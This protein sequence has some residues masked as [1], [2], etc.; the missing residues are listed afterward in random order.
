L[1][2]LTCISTPS[3]ILIVEDDPEF[4]L[5]VQYN[6]KAAGY[7]IVMM[8]NGSAAAAWLGLH[9]ADLMIVDCKVPGLSGIELVR[10]MRP[11][12]GFPPAILMTGDAGRYDRNFLLSLGAVD[13]LLKP[14]SMSELIACVERGLAPE[15]YSRLEYLAAQ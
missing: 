7:Q 15:S 4:S 6:L 3:R 14:F 13:C 1:R 11:Q 5:L 9:S 8:A 12:Y 10:R 2:D